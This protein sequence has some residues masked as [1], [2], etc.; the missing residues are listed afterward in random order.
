MDREWKVLLVG[1]ALAEDAGLD[2]RLRDDYALA[3]A[4]ASEAAERMA[5]AGG[6]DVVVVQQHLGEGEQGWICSSACGW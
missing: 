1:Q 3:R 6:I 4:A 2:G 5:T